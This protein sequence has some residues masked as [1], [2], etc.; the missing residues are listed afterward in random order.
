MNENQILIYHYSSKNQEWYDATD[1]IDIVR[2]D[3]NAWLVK[4]TNYKNKVHVSFSKMKI[5]DSAVEIKFSELYYKNALC[6]KVKKLICFNKVIYKI[7]YENGYTCVALPS[8][9]KII[10]D[11]LKENNTASGVMNYYRGVIQQLGDT[12]ENR[13][14]L[15]EFD[16]IKSV[17]DN[18]VLS[19]YLKGELSKND[20]IIKHPIIAPFG[21]N[22]SQHKALD[23]MFSNRISILE[24]PPGT[25]KTQTILNFI[26]NAVINNKSVA[27][28][29]NNNSAVDNVLEK[30]EKNGYSFFTAPLGNSDNV[31]AFFSTYDSGIPTFT[32]KKINTDE[33]KKLHDSLPNF[34]DLEN[35]KNKKIEEIKELELEHK[36]FLNN[37]HDIDFN[38]ISFQVNKI[39]LKNVLK[40][41][42][43]LKE[44]EK[45]LSILSKLFL[46]F[47]LKVP[48]HFF[49][50][51]P[52][53]YSDYLNNLY[54]LAK[55]NTLEKEIKKIEKEMKNESV[56]EKTDQYLI[57]SKIYFENQLSNIFNKNNRREYQKDDYKRDFIEFVKDY[58]VIL[59]STYSLAKCCNRRYMFD[60]LI[61]DESSQINMASAILSMRIA[62]NLIVVGD[63][64]QLPQIDSDLFKETNEKLLKQYKVPNNY[65]YYGN[66]IMSSLISLYGDK[67]SKTTLLEHYRCNP[68]I[69]SFCNKKFYDNRLI[70]YSKYKNDDYTMK[71]FKTAPGN[72][73]RKNPYGSGL[74]NQR[75]I[76]EI[77]ELLNNES[78][79]DVGIIAP[80]KY[81]TQKISEEI[82]GDI[83]ASTIHKFQGREKKTIIF[84]SV[85]NDAN[86]FVENDN[87]INVAVS[88]AIDKFIFVTSDKVAKSNNGILSDLVKY[89]SYHNDFG[90]IENGHIKSIYDLLYDD[91]KQEL[92][93]FRK[94][95]PSKDYDSENLTK[96][97]LKRILSNEYKTLYFKQHVS[98]K[99]FI[100]VK[101]LSLT[102]DE[103][104]FYM[105]PNSHVDFLIYNIMDKKPIL[106]IEV[107]GISFHEQQLKQTNR[108]LKKNSILEKAGIRLL[109]LK[110]NGSREEE[111]I[112]TCLNQTV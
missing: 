60:Y 48:K 111:K 23:M 7:F 84:S 20:S 22:L 74:Y 16:I 27:V 82:S 57:L 56:K 5:Y 37:N 94:R 49:E 70:I 64:K 6:F 106:A 14:L 63:L 91:Y 78:L 97:L 34:F 44:S 28:V 93:T 12:E 68:E 41:L 66:S 69:I 96:G 30:L 65:S 77:K 105:N 11:V 86:E 104:K 55:I 10:K 17:T 80:Y 71:V 4:F 90:V 95:H 19:L 13:F 40:M 72:F 98:L 21:I 81:Q 109:R 46:L 110:T 75:E 62:K 59:S 112:K 15:Q 26:A 51:K 29:S 25:G 39:K 18:S 102:N 67:I 103:Y 2:R 35:T 73:A 9:I 54:Y 50:L 52:E 99:D 76:D 43:K 85:I 53:E 1:L 47:K 24:G 61:M 79:D 32:N 36:H 92:E 33:I 8:E 107:D 108:D 101:D 38:K 3:N 31:D 89:I 83:E 42:I 58:P 45:K 100:N 87:L 88:R